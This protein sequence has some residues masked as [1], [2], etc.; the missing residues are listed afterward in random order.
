MMPL[1]NEAIYKI[2]REKHPDLQV[3]GYRPAD[4]TFVEGM[5]GITI[6]LENGDTLLYFP[7]QNCR[8]CKHNGKQTKMEHGEFS[9]C[10]FCVRLAVDY[11]DRGDSN[12]ISSQKTRANR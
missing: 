7:S 5:R 4:I 11:Y 8:G 12:E 2:F 6:W 10:S 3:T 1:T 9:P